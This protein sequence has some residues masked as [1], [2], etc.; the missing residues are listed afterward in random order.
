MANN[1]FIAF[2]KD[3]I[4]GVATSAYQI[5]GAWDEDGKGVSIWDTFCSQPGNIHQNEHGRTAADH[6][7]RL[8]EDL[9]LMQE[10]G[11]QAYRFSISWP[12]VQP[13]GKG[14][15]NQAGLDFYDRLVDGLL[16]RGIR[17]F[18]TLFH[19]DLPQALQDDGGWTSRDT[20]LAFGEYARI[21]GDCL[22]DRVTDWITHNE[23]LVVAL[24]GHLTGEHAPGIQDPVA[25]LQAGYHLLL[26]HGLAVQALRAATKPGS[27]VG[28]TLNLSPAHPASESEE[29]QAAAQRVDMVMN[30]TFLDPVLRGQYPE[31]AEALLGPLLPAAQPG[32]LETMSVPLD[33]LGI[34]Y[35]TRG[36]I[37]HDPDVPVMQ[38]S[39]VHPEGSE[40][41]QMW[42]IYP[43]GL[44]ELLSRVWDDYHPASILV[45]E[46][47]IPVPDGPD[48]DGKVR[49]YRRISYLREH[50]AQV[51]RVIGE[52]V[53]VDGYFVWSLLD[54]FEWAFGYRLR[55]G[56]VY[57]DFDTLKRTV[58]ESGR[59]YAS[60]IRSSGFEL[61]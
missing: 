19:W 31:G 15:P 55:F 9:D 4:W 42:E 30:K 57:V 6:Y 25:A 26:S 58:K 53:P 49:D 18:P 14:Q 34:N 11:L 13:G 12:R 16:E 51:Q 20:A 38:A 28:I 43:P 54:N 48:F 3:F 40:Y 7:H 29:D 47:G 27:K 8:D 33:F 24:L 39:A 32:D 23:P 36:V 50:L 22:G 56:L 44:Y 41:S 60:A 45:T 17:P 1:R 10:L 21:V 2:P 59:W 52:G 46:N 5:E 37:R 61:P 35:Y